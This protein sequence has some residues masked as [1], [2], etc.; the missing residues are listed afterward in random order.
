MARTG[1]PRAFDKDEKL[2]MALNLFW[3]RGYAATSIQDL[4]DALAV[5]RGS[6]YAAFGDKRDLYLEA[7][8]LY[9]RE[10]EGELVAALKAEPLLP[11]LRWV[12]TNPARLDDFASEVGV[13]HGCLMG[14]TSAE[15]VPRDAGARDI[16]AH[17]YGRFV[18]IVSDALQRAQERG[19][20]VDTSPATA[21]AQMLLYFVQGFSLVS[22]A[23][24][25]AELS[26]AAVDA[27]IE[28]L[29]A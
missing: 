17:S 14:N 12:L 23:G 5:E 25:D 7:V 11:A 28:S 21:Q 2:A 15:L 26:L 22:R 13:P 29:R 6:L 3:S 18:E 24:M 10:Y 9:W 16:V 20:V 8:K 4:V 27:A 19:E 1:R